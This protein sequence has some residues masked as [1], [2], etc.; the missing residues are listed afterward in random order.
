MPPRKTRARRVTEEA[1]KA[2]ARQDLAS[3]L[4]INV[5]DVFESVVHNVNSPASAPE[6][7]SYFK[8]VVSRKKTSKEGQA[9]S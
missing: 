7:F 9:L 6:E 4:I 5:P 2:L 3:S 1:A 8:P